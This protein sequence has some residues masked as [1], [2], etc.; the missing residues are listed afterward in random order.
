MLR[1]Q[2][3]CN[4]CN[5]AVIEKEAIMMIELNDWRKVYLDYLIKKVMPDDQKEEQKLKKHMD[6]YL[7]K[8]GQLYRNACNG[9]ILRC[10]NGQEAEEVLREIHEVDCGE[11]QG[12]RRLCEEA[13]RLGY[14]WPTIE[15]DV[16]NYA[17]RCQNCQLFGNKVHTPSVN[18]H[19]TNVPWPF[20]TWA[21]DLIGPISPPSKGRIWILTAT[22]S[23]LNGPRL[24]H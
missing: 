3:Q 17:Q 21:L 7:A 18:L 23:L 4:I 6:K 5:K 14:F 8:E 1:Q 12:G 20:H 2:E 10:I 19:S 9:E 13:L 16:M 15:K 11:H 22:E 24:F